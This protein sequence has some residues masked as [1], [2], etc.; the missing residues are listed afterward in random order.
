MGRDCAPRAVRPGRS[1]RGDRRAVPVES[2]GQWLRKRLLCRCR[3]GRLAEL[4]GLVLRI[5]GRTQFHHRRQTAR[6]AVGDRIVGAPVRDEQLVCAGASGRHGGGFCC[7][8][9]LHGSPR[10]RRYLSRRSGRSA[11]RRGAGMYSGGGVDLPVQQPRRTAGAVDA[12]G[13][14][15]PD[16]CRLDGVMAMAGVGGCGDRFR[17]PHQDAAG[18]S[19]VARFRACLPALGA[20]HVATADPSSGGRDGRACRRCRLVGVDGAVG[21]GVREALYRRFDRQ[22]RAGSGFG[23]QRVKPHHGP[24]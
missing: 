6:L 1:A 24:P 3:T 23:L 2:L 13:G 21:A 7:P 5:S 14:V 4:V 10:I 17:V 20:Y 19:G 9:V 18:V 11:G 22:H 12:G 16:A 15:L 8:A